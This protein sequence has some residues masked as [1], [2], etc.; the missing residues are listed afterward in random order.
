M[1]FEQLRWLIGF[2]P[3]TLR[4]LLPPK[5]PESQR[6]ESPDCI[7]RLLGLSC[8]PAAGGGGKGVG[9]VETN[10]SKDATPFQVK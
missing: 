4:E 3:E 7:R 6:P 2:A 9:G 5:A 1:A 8:K 10:Y